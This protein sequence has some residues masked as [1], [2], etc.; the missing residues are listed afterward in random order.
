MKLSLALSILLILFPGG[1]WSEESI[2]LFND[3][4]FKVD[5]NSIKLIEITND[6]DFQ[7]ETFSKGENKFLYVTQKKAKLIPPLVQKKRIDKIQ[8][9]QHFDNAE[10]QLLYSDI[11]VSESYVQRKLPLI[12]LLADF[13]EL[14]LLKYEYTLEEGMV[15]DVIK[16]WD[17][18]RIISAVN[19]SITSVMFS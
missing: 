9:K 1:V 11:S 2:Y 15:T 13:G 8:T 4:Q 12:L 6:K 7:L 14:T 17:D 10:S 3:T 5:S 18:M 16:N 19:I